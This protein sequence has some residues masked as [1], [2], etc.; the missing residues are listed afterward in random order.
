MILKFPTVAGAMGRVRELEQKLGLPKGGCY[1]NIKHANQRVAELEALAARQVPPAPAAAKPS[2]TPA[3]T[4]AAPVFTRRQCETIMAEVFHESRMTF[5]ELSDA[6]LLED[7]VARIA[8]AHLIC[9]G[10]K[11]T[12]HT[13]R[14]RGYAAI[15]HGAR[16][17]ALN[18]TLEGF[19]TQ[20]K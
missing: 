3:P 11:S 2:Y 7:T 15:I 17:D 9:S 18:R 6:A 19:K 1:L 12:A 5:A 10:V 16:Q 8:A 13:D 4:A 14:P 20:R